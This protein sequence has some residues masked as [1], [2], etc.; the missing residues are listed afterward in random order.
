VERRQLHHCGN[1]QSEACK[2]S[3]CSGCSRWWFSRRL[4]P[5]WGECG[6]GKAQPLPLSHC[7]L[8]FASIAPVQAMQR[9]EILKINRTV[10]E[11]VGFL[12]AIWSCSRQVLATG[13]GSVM[14]LLPFKVGL[15]MGKRPLLMQLRRQDPPLQLKGTKW[16]GARV[17]VGGYC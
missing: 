3:F 8:A 1:R 16:V 7:P 17:C 12:I 10:G 11:E 5:R 14:G 4:N 15:G 9:R 6:I 13:G 2:R